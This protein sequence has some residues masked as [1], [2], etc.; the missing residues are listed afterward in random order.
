MKEFCIK[1]DQNT[2]YVFPTEEWVHVVD[3]EMPDC[4]KEKLPLY[5][6]IRVYCRSS[7]DVD[8]VVHELERTRG[9]GKK[10]IDRILSEAGWKR[11]FV[12]ACD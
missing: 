10:T 4:I 12:A 9:I 8:K 11:G 2:L 6:A 3:C 1:L 5:E 7:A